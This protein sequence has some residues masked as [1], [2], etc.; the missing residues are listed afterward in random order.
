MGT[1]VTGLFSSV[2]SLWVFV[3]VCP[4]DMICFGEYC[5]CMAVF[6]VPVAMGLFSLVL[7]L[8]LG[9]GV[10]GEGSYGFAVLFFFMLLL[11]LIMRLWVCFC[12]CCGYSSVFV[13][14]GFYGVSWRQISLLVIRRREKQS[15]CVTPTASN[16]FG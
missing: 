11:F 16:C 8:F 14:Q 3:S 7:W 15:N 4:V 9:G 5:G 12:G 13:D 10:R 6:V 1:M 2:L